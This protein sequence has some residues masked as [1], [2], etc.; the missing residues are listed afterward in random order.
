MGQR[1]THAWDVTVPDTYVESHI[2][3]TAAKPGGAANKTAQN[4]TVNYAKLASTHIFYPFAVETAGTWH[5]MA[6][7][8]TQKIGR[9][10]TA[11]TEDTRET[12]FLFQRLSIALQRGNAV[13][14]HNTM[15]TERIAVAIIL[16]LLSLM[17]RAAALCWG[18]PNKK[19]LKFTFNT[20]CNICLLDAHHV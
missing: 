3:S 2:G 14:F 6:I 11:I 19:T 15:V 13:S 1:K 10:I 4:K 5:H 8:L 20:A 18:G 7:E 16:I 17:F 12:T 9:R